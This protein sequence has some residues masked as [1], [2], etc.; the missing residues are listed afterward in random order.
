[1][2]RF[3]LVLAVLAVSTSA[4]LIRAAEPM[5]ALT[6]AV[7]RVTAAALIL[8][9][10][11]PT[12]LALLVRLPGRERARVL[13]AGVL[14]GAHFAVWISSLSF[15]STAASVALVATQPIAAALLGGIFLGDRV[16]RREVAGMAVAAAGCLVLAGGDWSRSR[17]ALIGDG[18]ALAGAVTAAAYLV[19]GRSLRGS[20]PLLP[21]LAL[22]NLTAAAVLAVAAAIG[23]AQLGGWSTGEYGAVLACAA[24]G[25]IIGHSLF[26]WSVRRIPAHQVT[27]ASLGEPVAASLLVWLLFAEQPP[28]HAVAG[29]AL[30]LAGILVA[31]LR[32]RV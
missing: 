12:A 3:V 1:V 25:S 10:A 17:D 29:G 23:G 6:F 13:L 18:L 2:S 16:T 20:V 8:S 9:L 22:V 27:L 4:P 5:P 32:R 19:I 30:I 15:T 28:L 24:L 31:F 14:L 7:L 11:A 21:Y 26:N